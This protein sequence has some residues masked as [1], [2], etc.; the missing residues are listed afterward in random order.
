MPKFKPASWNPAAHSRRSLSK[1]EVRTAG[2]LG[3]GCGSKARRRVCEVPSRRY[4]RH[5]STLRTRARA[6]VL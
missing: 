5:M 2:D 3:V 6:N 1:H 4:E